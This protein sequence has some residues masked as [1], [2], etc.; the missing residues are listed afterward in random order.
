[1]GNEPA[2]HKPRVPDFSYLCCE[3]DDSFGTQRVLVV[4]VVVDTDVFNLSVVYSLSHI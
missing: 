1:M 2:G 4:M 3:L